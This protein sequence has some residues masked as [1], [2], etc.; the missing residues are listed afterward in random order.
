MNLQMLV[1]LIRIVLGGLI[2]LGGLGK[3]LDV[4]GFARV[5]ETYRFN[6]SRATLW[7]VA[8]GATTFELGLGLSLLSGFQLQT[9]ALLSIVMHAFYAIILFITL[10]RG[11]KLPN[12]GCFGVFHARPLRWYTPVLDLVMIALSYLLYILA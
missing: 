2:S 4:P 10:A 3:V 7:L 6:L 5:L 12:C 11:I 1:L 9:S 8:V